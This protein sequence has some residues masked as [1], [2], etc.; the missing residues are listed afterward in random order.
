MDPCHVGYTD[1]GPNVTARD[2]AL[3]RGNAGNEEPAETYPVC[4]G[5]V[6]TGG[7]WTPCSRT[8]KDYLGG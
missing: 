6:T 1:V 8:W 4:P 5:V 7:A 3:V 2:P